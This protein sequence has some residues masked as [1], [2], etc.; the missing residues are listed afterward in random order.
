MNIQKRSALHLPEHELW[1]KSS[2]KGKV[3][4]LADLIEPD[5]VIFA[6]RTSNKQQLLQDLAS[7]AAALLNL[8]APDNLHCVKGSRR[9]GFHRP[10]Q[11]YR[12]P[13]C[14]HRRAR[15]AFRHVHAPRIGRFISIRST[16]DLSISCFSYSSH[17]RLVAS[18][19]PPLLVY[20]GTCVTRNSLRDCGKPQ[21]LPCCA[22][23]FAIARI[24]D[25]PGQTY[26]PS[27]SLIP[28]QSDARWCQVRYEIELRDLNV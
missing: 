3:M 2:C 18:I 7:R 24:C 26:N 11:W 13:A 10:R 28:A 6:A 27:L 25:L 1:A 21:A 4:D 12:A 15:P 8:D 19:S 23:Y 17:R 22:A 16:T 9:A 14:P 20:R 5:R